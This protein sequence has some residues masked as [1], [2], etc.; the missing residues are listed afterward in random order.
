MRANARRSTKPLLPRLPH[1]PPPLLL[2]VTAPPHPRTTL[3]LL[4]AAPPHPRSA[5]AAVHAE[6]SP[7]PS[8]RCSS[9]SPLLLIPKPPPPAAP[10][11]AAPVDRRIRV[12]GGHRRWI[13]RRTTALAGSGR[14][15]A[16]PSP[17]PAAA[18]F[19][20]AGT[21]A[22]LSPA[23]APWPAAAP[24]PTAAVDRRC[25]CLSQIRKNGMV[26][27]LVSTCESNISIYIC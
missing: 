24:S 3:L 27:W 15:T 22:A 19:V 23:A 6:R 20:V 25:N 8:R 13:Q 10:S 11:P 14:G 4:V 1:P 18:P 7:D 26:T 21:A 5:A 2:L 9:S 12:W 17:S 16:P